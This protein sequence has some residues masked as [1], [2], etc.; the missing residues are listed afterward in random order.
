MRPITPFTLP[1]VWLDTSRILVWVSQSTDNC[2]T[3]DLF[4]AIVPEDLAVLNISKYIES[5][6]V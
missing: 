1:D 4:R 6:R 5:S 2:H 3:Y